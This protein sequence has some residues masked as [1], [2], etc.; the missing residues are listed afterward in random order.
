MK[1]IVLITVT[2]GGA[3]RSEYTAKDIAKIEKSYDS[4]HNIEECSCYNCSLIRV[5]KSSK[6]GEE[7]VPKFIDNSY[8]F[9]ID[10]SF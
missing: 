1:K 8:G 10:D 2:E 4:D 9:I 7:I 6:I 5:F 3:D